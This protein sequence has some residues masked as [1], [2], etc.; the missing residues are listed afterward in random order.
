MD[1]PFFDPVRAR[2]EAEV[3]SQRQFEQRR[4]DHSFADTDHFADD[5]SRLEED[6]TSGLSTT[7]SELSFLSLSAPDVLR[8]QLSGQDLS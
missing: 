5:P 8:R 4:R 7:R 3:F 2:V 1:H 6:G